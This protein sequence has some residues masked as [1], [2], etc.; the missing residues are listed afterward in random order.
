MNPS[1]FCKKKIEKA[2]Q[3]SS[4]FFLL[5]SKEKDGNSV[6]EEKKTEREKELKT[7]LFC[8]CGFSGFEIKCASGIWNGLL[9]VS[10][11]VSETGA[12]SVPCF[13]PC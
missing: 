6:D 4:L 10:C 3:N 12:P 8:C 11:L 13:L 5:K 2:K 9:R 7:H 1:V